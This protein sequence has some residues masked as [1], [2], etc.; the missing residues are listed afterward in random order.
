MNPTAYQ[1][2]ACALLLFLSQACS[3]AMHDDEAPDSQFSEAEA[4]LHRH[5]D[6]LMGARALSEVA[7]EADRYNTDMGQIMADMDDSMFMMSH[8]SEADMSEMHKRMSGMVSDVAKH[9][10]ALGGA[11]D[12]PSARAACASHVKAM[13]E[14]FSSMHEALDRTQCSMMGH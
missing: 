13:H 8:C 11:S 4:E 7:D 1:R 5:H 12:M 3:S 6:Q 2:T 14:R 9:W 10:T